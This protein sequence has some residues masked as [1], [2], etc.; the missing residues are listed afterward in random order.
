LHSGPYVV[1]PGNIQGRH[2]REAG[3]KGCTLVHVEEGAIRGIE[4]RDT[5]VLRWGVCEIDAS[6]VSDAES[7]LDLVRAALRRERERHDGLPL[8]L[9]VRIAGPCEAHSALCST[10]D[11]W[12]AEVRSAATE[13]G[14]VWIEKVRIET[15]QQHD[16]ASILQRDDPLARLIRSIHEM[17]AAPGL[18]DEFLPE[19]EDLKRK[20]PAELR[21]GS[22]LLALSDDE[23]R[24][25]CLDEVRQMLLPRL[26]ALPEPR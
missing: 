18:L 16:L 10:P 3:P 15:S 12:A 13:L 9:R 23:K 1:F 14:E 24:R 5:D 8:A 6:G 22:Q 26:F 17:E 2:V 19:L 11:R 21:E 4:H 7:V 25:R 20:L